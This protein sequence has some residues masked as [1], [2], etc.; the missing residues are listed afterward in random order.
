MMAEIGKGNYYRSFLNTV[1]TQGVPRTIPTGLPGGT[2]TALTASAVSREASV[3]TPS[4]SRAS[5]CA[6]LSVSC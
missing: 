2:I 6:V 4:I 5:E 3:H 1:L